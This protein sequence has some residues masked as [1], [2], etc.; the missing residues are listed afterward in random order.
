MRK[1]NDSVEENCNS[2]ERLL[3]LQ[4]S[5]PVAQAIYHFDLGKTVSVFSGGSN[6]SLISGQAGAHPPIAPYRCVKWDHSAG[7]STHYLS[8]WGR[9]RL[10]R[11][12]YS[13]I[14]FALLFLTVLSTK[15]VCNLRTL[16]LVQF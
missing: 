9:E 14:T 12:G 6:P 1:R 10:R 3:I 4:Q 16:L 15:S 8:G 2:Q 7:M 11:T 13:G 5:P